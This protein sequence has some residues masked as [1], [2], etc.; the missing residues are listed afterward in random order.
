MFA[1]QSNIT[2]VKVKAVFDWFAFFVWKDNGVE[3]L[4]WFITGRCEGWFFVF[5]KDFVSFTKFLTSRCEF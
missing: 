5:Y 2:Q 4:F 3:K 1:M